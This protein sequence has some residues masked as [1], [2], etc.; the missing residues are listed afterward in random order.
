MRGRP[1]GAPQQ[2]DQAHA[3]FGDEKGEVSGNL[4]LWKWIN[5]ARGGGPS[6]PSGRAQKAMAIH[7]APWK[8]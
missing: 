4:K 6:R 5:G 1:R 3:K 8:G 7:K 2:A